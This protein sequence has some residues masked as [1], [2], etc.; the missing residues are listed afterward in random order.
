MGVKFKVDRYFKARG[1]CCDCV[2]IIKCLC[3][4]GQEAEVVAI[5]YTR[6]GKNWKQVSNE[7]QFKISARQYS[8]WGEFKPRG[9]NDV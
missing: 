6:I 7:T 5:W 9:L 2:K 8:R 3:D 4:T 1:D